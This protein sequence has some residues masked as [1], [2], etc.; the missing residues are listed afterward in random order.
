MMHRIRDGCGA[1]LILHVDLLIKDQPIAYQILA[2]QRFLV[3]IHTGDLV[4]VV[5]GIVVYPFICV[6]AGSIDRPLILS[7]S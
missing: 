7:I 1:V 2:L 4:V 3:H 6:A 5:G